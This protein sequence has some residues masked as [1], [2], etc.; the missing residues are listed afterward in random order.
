M[1][2]IRSGADRR[3]MADTGRRTLTEYET[4]GNERRRLNRESITKWGVGR[5][6]IPLR[7]PD[8]KDTTKLQ[9]TLNESL[10]QAYITREMNKTY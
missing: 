10:H 7:L 8:E 9:N 2:F 5:S 6:E 1:G 4:S 3:L